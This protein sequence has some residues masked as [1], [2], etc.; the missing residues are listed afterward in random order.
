VEE[1]SHSPQQ[2]ELS[3]P[4]PQLNQSP[5]ATAL[6]TATLVEQV[7]REIAQLVKEKYG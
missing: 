2:V 6:A 4:L 3:P 5:N 7:L 1:A